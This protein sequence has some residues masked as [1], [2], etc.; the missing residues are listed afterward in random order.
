M[1]R[2]PVLEGSKWLRGLT[3]VLFWLILQIVLLVLGFAILIQFFLV[4]FGAATSWLQG[5]C[6]SLTTY[7]GQILRYLGFA[8]EVRPF[9]FSEWPLAD[10]ITVPEADEEPPPDSESR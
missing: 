10:E 2:H 1:A 3:M 9:P 7:I 4:L 8:S 5:F 6:N